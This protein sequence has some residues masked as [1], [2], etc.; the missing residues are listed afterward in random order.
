MKRRD[1]L[2]EINGL[3]VDDLKARVRSMSE[4]LMK[5]RFRLTTGQLDQTHRIREL[6]RNLARAQ[7]ALTARRQD[8]QGKAA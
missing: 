1:T 7:T 5:L 6:K 3:P 4:E 8:S 2:K